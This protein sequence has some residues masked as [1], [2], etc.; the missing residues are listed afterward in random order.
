MKT[1]RRDSA[2]KIH[3]VAES[4]LHTRMHTLADS[5]SARISSTYAAFETLR[6]FSFAKLI[7]HEDGSYT[8]DV[9]GVLYKLYAASW[10]E[11]LGAAAYERGDRRAASLSGELME[12]FVDMEVGTDA[13]PMMNAWYAGYDAAA[14]KAAQD[15][16]TG[17]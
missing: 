11:A 7:D 5:S 14:D 13:E 3:A 15:I 2:R 8:I 10:F 9:C 6:K 16:L 4:I 1:I 17:P 12:L